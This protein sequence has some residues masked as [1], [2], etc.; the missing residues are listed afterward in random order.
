MSTVTK[1]TN[2]V[3]PEVM[4]L[5]VSAMLPKKIKFSINR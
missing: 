3:N 1:K 5:I 4:A 2:L